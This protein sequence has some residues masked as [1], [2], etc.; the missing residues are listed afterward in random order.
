MATNVPTRET[1]M[2]SSVRLDGLLCSS[3]QQVLRI[4]RPVL[5]TFSIE[6]QI[7]V[8]L[9]AALDAVTHRRLDTVIVDWNGAY[10]PIRVLRATRNSSWNSKSTILAV[11]NEDHEMHSALRSGANFLIHKPSDV[12]GV[13]RCMRAAYGTMLLQRRRSARLSVDIPVIARFSE[14]G[15]IEARIS[16]ISAGGVALQCTQAVSINLQV[17]MSFMLPSSNILMHVAGKVVNA[18][19][20]GRAGVCF[21]FV[22]ENELKL[23]ESWLSIQ[24][25]RMSEA[26][27]PSNGDPKVH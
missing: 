1:L 22:P 16:D 15:K 17:S 23:L 18:H 7:C 20:N 24:L 3:D 12:D 2:K 19:A 6:T 4:M 14:L 9:P 25:N 10:N 5:D 27:L 8:E 11:V 26:E 21:S 13:S